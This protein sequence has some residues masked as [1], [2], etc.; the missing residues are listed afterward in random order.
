[1]SC[2]VHRSSE[3]CL[4][5]HHNSDRNVAYSSSIHLPFRM[6]MFPLSAKYSMILPSLTLRAAATSGG[7][8]SRKD[9]PILTTVR[10]NASG[11]MPTGY[12]YSGALY[13]CVCFQAVIIRSAASSITNATPTPIRS[14][15]SVVE[16]F[17]APTATQTIPI[18]Q[19]CN[20]NPATVRCDAY[21]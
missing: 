1:M 2:S 8:V 11:I 6:M 12:P 9:P 4:G 10:L 15:P 20:L 13:L 21:P 17:Q 16:R 3:V 5:A 18:I 19:W 7:S 14:H